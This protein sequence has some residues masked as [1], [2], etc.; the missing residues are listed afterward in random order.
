M[1]S[2]YW[3]PYRGA[4]T[5]REAMD[6][7]LQD[8]YVRP[9]GRSAGGSFPLDVAETQDG[10][11]VR[12][13]LPGVKPEDVHITVHGDRLTI[14]GETRE[15]PEQRGQRWLVREHRAGVLQRSIALPAP[16][17]AQQAEARFDHGM[18]VVTLPKAESARPRRIPVGGRPR[19]ATLAGEGSLGPPGLRDEERALGQSSGEAAKAGDH[20][21]Q[22]SDD[23]FPAS[24]PPSWT[25]E[26]A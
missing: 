2:E 6:R 19:D 25:P 17:D 4:P 5:L 23:S 3:D 21:T 26:R 14:R 22:A 13:S 20:V 15:E 24:D 9:A 12:A 18:L 8:S 1:P 11:L 10:F 16:V 7:L